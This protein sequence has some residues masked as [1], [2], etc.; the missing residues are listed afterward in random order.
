MRTLIISTDEGFKLWPT[1]EEHVANC[2]YPIVAIYDN[3]VD[4]EAGLKRAKELEKELRPIWQ[5]AIE[6][7]RRV[8][9]MMLD[10]VWKAAKP[11]ANQSEP[12]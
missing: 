8:K 2:E 10:L 6:H 7:E 9:E 12:G 5:A 11:L 1:L 4:A 3:D